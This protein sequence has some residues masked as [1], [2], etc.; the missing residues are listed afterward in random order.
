MG[1]GG[2]EVIA[3]DVIAPFR[4]QPNAGPIV[5]PQPTPRSLFLGDFQALPAPDAADT[6]LANIP[7][8]GLQQGRDPAIAVPTVLRSQGDNGPRQPILVSPNRGDISLCSPWLADD[9]AG[10]AFREPITLPSRRDRL[11][12]P[13]GR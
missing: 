8:R 3:P 12:P 7:P 11:P 5:Q 2:H 4:P 9:A 13:V 6:V 10:A 1:L